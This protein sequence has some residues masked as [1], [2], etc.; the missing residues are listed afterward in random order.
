MLKWTLLPKERRMWLNVVLVGLAFAAGEVPGVAAPSV[1]LITLDGVRHQEVF[2]N[3]P[4]PELSSEDKAPIFPK[5]WARASQGVYFGAPGGREASVANLAMLSLPAYQSIFTGSFPGCLS[6]EC[7]KVAKETFPE[8]LVRELSISKDSVAAFSSWKTI[9]ERAL[10]NVPGSVLSDCGEPDQTVFPKALDYL[11]ARRPMFLYVALDDSDNWAHK[12]NYPEYLKALRRFDGWID[13][14]LAAVGPQTTVIL[15]TDHGRGTGKDWTSHGG[16]P[17]AAA[18]WMFVW[19]PKVS[20][21]GAAGEGEAVTH[22]D[23]R[24]TVETLLGLK[25]QTCRSCGKVIPEA[26]GLHSLQRDGR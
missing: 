26:L 25:P 18:I 22:L 3:R 21:K 5:L 6:N 4:D 8:R 10:E 24:P 23:I 17:Q 7:E 20:T 2:S 19:G 16:R 9:C 1:V 13:E 11:K 14:L 12:D 15:T